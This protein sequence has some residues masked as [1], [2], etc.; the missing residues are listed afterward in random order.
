MSGANVQHV[1]SGQEFCP[2]DQQLM[3]IAAHEK[4]PRRFATDPNTGRS[5]QVQEKAWAHAAACYVASKMPESQGELRLH[6]AVFLPLGQPK[7]IAITACPWSVDLF[8]HGWFF[9]NSG[10]TAVEAIEEEESERALTA[11]DAGNSGTVRRNWNQRLA[12]CGTLLLIP[13]AFAAIAE[14]CRW[15]DETT[16]KFTYALQRSGLFTR[17]AADICQRDGWVRRLVTD[18]GNA[19]QRIPAHTAVYEIP[20]AAAGADVCAVFPAMR[21]IAA[22]EVIV[23]RGSPRLMATSAQPWPQQMVRELLRS[24]PGDRLVKSATSLDYLVRFLDES[25]S[26]QA[27]SVHA[28]DLVDLARS[29][30]MER[31]QPNDGESRKAVRRFLARLPSNRRIRLRLEQL[32]GAAAEMFVVL[33]ESTASISWVPDELASADS[34]CSGQL[35][36]GEALHVLRKLSQWGQRSLTSA[37][38]ERLGVIAAQVFRATADLATLLANAG[39][40][41]LFNGIRC[42]DRRKESRVS[43]SDIVEH[44]R[45]RV[46]FVK[47]SPMAYQLQEAL[48]DENIVLISKELSEA[49]FGESGNGPAQ[50]REGQLLAALAVAEKP[51]L[52]SVSSRR[53]LFESLLKF[54]DGRREPS[55]RNCLRYLLHGSP[56]CFSASDSLLVQGTTGT[57]WWRLARISLEALGQR[58]RIVDAAFSTIISDDDRRELGVAI[59][60]AE[61]ALELAAQVDPHCFVAL[62]PSE[63]EYRDLLKQ[64]ADDDLLRRLPIHEDRDG[65]FTGISEGC[66]WESDR[67]LPDGL[68]HDVRVLKRSADD[69]AW[70]R[71]QQL[72]SPLDSAAV[73]KIALAQQVPA[74][75]WALIMD[76]VNECEH[77]SPDTVNRLKTTAWVPA[78]VSNTVKPEDIVHLPELEDDVARLVSQYPGV[79]VDPEGL[80]PAIRRHAG[81]ARLLSIAA[82]SRSDALGMVGTLL[83]EDDRNC[84]GDVG[85][86]FDDWL[87][88]IREPALLGH[89]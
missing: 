42:R 20:G 49:I 65:E 7:S 74:S 31:R 54:R 43:W 21:E 89:T 16:A 8:L 79:F 25:A 46:L 3:E 35:A 24:A 53:P 28:D 27:W 10:R 15:D 12:R 26:E 77:I 82:P 51:M 38:T 29:M 22:T 68:Q 5:H 6:W 50:C 11:S 66:F 80:S 19:W 88:T 47:P 40:I 84:V 52:G 32:E 30:L 57:V 85:V 70:K 81:F 63:L 13:S 1:Y 37:E 23:A 17:F 72:T 55:F 76:C 64:I 58:W 61:V 45:R 60:D 75:H 87:E 71:Q 56:E 62:R 83:L 14:Q 33:C 9:P 2:S 59:V 73:M 41:E 67:S 44:H 69:G 86:E 4:W 18:G 78:T 48:P 39:N 36:A 34:A